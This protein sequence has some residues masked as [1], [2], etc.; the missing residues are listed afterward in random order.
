MDKCFFY[1]VIYY[2]LI[3]IEGKGWVLEKNLYMY[4]YN[5]DNY[6]FFG[7]DYLVYIGLKV[8]LKVR[9]VIL[10]LKVFNYNKKL[11]KL[12]MYKKVYYINYVNNNVNY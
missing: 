10:I 5:E 8:W 9:G 2:L 3:N 1:C 7:V 11:F 12:L 6:F 4:W